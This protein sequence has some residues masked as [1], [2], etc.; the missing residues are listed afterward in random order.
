MHTHCLYFESVCRLF[1]CITFHNVSSSFFK[2][3]N[4]FAYLGGCFSTL[5]SY[6]VSSFTLPR[7]LSLIFSISSE[8]LK[9]LKSHGASYF[10][11]FSGKWGK[12]KVQSKT[13]VHAAYMLPGPT[14][15]PGFLD[16]FAALTGP[17][18]GMLCC[19]LR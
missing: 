2:A 8:L 15:P 13:V 18:A 10:T 16:E 5:N 9:N 19:W 3:D 12:G 7:T 14:H 4:A 17:H 6:Y 1:V 11:G